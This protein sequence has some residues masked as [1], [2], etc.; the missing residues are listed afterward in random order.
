MLQVRR[1][2]MANSGTLLLCNVDRTGDLAA[3]R[4]QLKAGFPHGPVKQPTIMHASL[5]RLL[6]PRQLT[7]KE[8]H[9][10]LLVIISTAQCMQGMR[11]GSSSVSGCTFWD[12]APAL[13]THRSLYAKYL[14]PPGCLCKS[15]RS[16]CRLRT[17]RRCVTHG[18]K[19]FAE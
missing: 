1:L 2:V 3:L 16:I 7:T 9:V 8:V 10:M 19:S 15:S 18:Q 6:T 14:H 11:F 5:L 13:R 12:M 4:Q 17:Y